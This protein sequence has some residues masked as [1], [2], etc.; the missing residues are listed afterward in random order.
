MKK[1]LLGPP[2]P[3]VQAIYLR[4]VIEMSDSPIEVV[5]AVL[6]LRDLLRVPLPSGGGLAVGVSAR[7]HAENIVAVLDRR[8]MVM[9]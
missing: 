7:E 6:R 3:N 5:E 4:A 8:E 9:W 2:T 1:P